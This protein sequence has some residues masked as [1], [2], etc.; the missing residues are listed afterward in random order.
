VF[1][2]SGGKVYYLAGI[3]PVLLAAGA[4]PTLRW[5]R[6]GRRRLRRIALALALVLSALSSVAIALPVAPLHDLHKTS[7]EYDIG[8]T[9]A[10][11]TYV[12]EIATAWNRLPASVRAHAAI[13]T[14]NY[15]EAGAVDR[16]RPGLGLPTAYSGHMGFWYWGP[17]P[18]SA[19]SVLGVGFDPGYLQRFFATVRLVSRLNNHLQVNNDEQ[20]APLWFASGLRESWHQIWPKFKDLG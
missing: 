13:L 18:A 14:S 7:F 9:V 17:P 4:E 11:P 10:W 16:Y 6:R 19:T 3:Y 8:E 12:R 2:I 1:L 20:H 5:L 15:G